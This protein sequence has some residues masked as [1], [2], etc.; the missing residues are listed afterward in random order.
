MQT[1]NTKYE[2]FK[3]GDRIKVR[4]TTYRI[5]E[6]EKI[7]DLEDFNKEYQ[8]KENIKKEIDKLPNPKKLK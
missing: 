7:F 5:I 4:K 1:P 8:E 3:E 6:E 2:K